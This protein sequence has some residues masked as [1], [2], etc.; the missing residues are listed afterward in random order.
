MSDQD[1]LNSRVTELVADG[2]MPGLAKRFA[3]AEHEQTPLRVS[4]DEAIELIKRHKLVQ[5]DADIAYP[6]RPSPGMY[7]PY[8][9]VDR[10]KNT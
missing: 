9:I 6:H 7:W 4:P 8:V 3:A 10:T 2:M 5:S 1:Q